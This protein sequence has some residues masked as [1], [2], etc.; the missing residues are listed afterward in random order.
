MSLVHIRVELNPSLKGTRGFTSLEEFDKSLT[1]IIVERLQGV[2]SNGIVLD[3]A[4]QFESIVPDIGVRMEQTVGYGDESA[5][6][7]R[8]VVE[9]LLSVMS[10]LFLPRPPARMFALGVP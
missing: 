5:K 3:R 6:V 1:V 7:D 9:E 4:E 2:S 10:T 8:K